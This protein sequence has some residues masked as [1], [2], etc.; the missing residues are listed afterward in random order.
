V[1]TLRVRHLPADAVRRLRHRVSAQQKIRQISFKIPVCATG[2]CT[3]KKSA[4][5]VLES[6]K[7]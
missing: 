6:P 7:I 5:S 4:K 1:E 2:V 3:T